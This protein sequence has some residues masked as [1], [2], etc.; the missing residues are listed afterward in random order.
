V[1][2]DPSRDDLL[3]GIEVVLALSVAVATALPALIRV[4]R[5][6]LIGRWL[7]RDKTLKISIGGDS[8]ELHGVSTEEQARIIEEWLRRHAGRGHQ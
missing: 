3:V 6:V 4:L 8:I 7:Q 1:I 2:K 5:Q